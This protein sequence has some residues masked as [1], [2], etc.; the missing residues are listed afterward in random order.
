MACATLDEDLGDDEIFA[1]ASVFDP[2]TGVTV[3][4]RSNTVTGTF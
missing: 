2:A 4:I 1:V 3:D